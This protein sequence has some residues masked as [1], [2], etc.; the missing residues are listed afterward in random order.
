[1]A[2][3]TTQFSRSFQEAILLFLKKDTLYKLFF[4]KF[5]LH[6]F[7]PIVSNGVH[8]NSLFNTARNFLASGTHD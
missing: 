8:N 5:S 6:V 2:F 3:G 4:N 7:S 1:M